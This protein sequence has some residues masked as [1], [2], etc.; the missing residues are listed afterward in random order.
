MTSWIVFAAAVAH[1]AGSYRSR[2]R[3]SPAR[4]AGSPTRTVPYGHSSSLSP[5]R[6]RATSPSPSSLLLAPTS[7]YSPGRTSPGRTLSPIATP[8]SP[9]GRTVSVPDR[10]S[11]RYEAPCMRAARPRP[12]DTCLACPAYADTRHLSDDLQ[13]HESYPQPYCGHFQQWV[14]R[15][16]CFATA[17]HFQHIQDRV[18]VT[19]AEL[20]H[21]EPAVYLHGHL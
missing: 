7:L 6:H 16:L 4:G 3:S 9:G 17:Q 19:D 15:S 2:Y 8:R 13:I 1:C 21:C 12:C 14:A 5:S 18:S 10:S 11:V 20:R